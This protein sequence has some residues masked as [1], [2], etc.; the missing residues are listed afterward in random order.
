M[1]N[2]IFRIIKVKIFNPRLPAVFFKF[3]NLETCTLIFY[4]QIL[5]AEKLAAI[6]EKQHWV[7][8]EIPAKRGKILAADNF[9]L[10]TNKEAFLVFASIPDL[11]RSPEQI[12]AKIARFLLDEEGNDK[13]EEAELKKTEIMIKQRLS[14]QDLFGCH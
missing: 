12:A 9:P 2:T 4:W 5:A 8:F 11:N 7:S 14:R 3:I 10:V 1:Y 13:Q 6:G